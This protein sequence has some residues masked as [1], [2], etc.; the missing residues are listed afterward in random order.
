MH[1]SCARK[2]VWIDLNLIDGL[3]V[4]CQLGNP[5]IDESNYNVGQLEDWCSH[6]LISDLILKLETSI[7]STY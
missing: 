3:I 6:G 2:I 7:L 5:T 4:H 1:R